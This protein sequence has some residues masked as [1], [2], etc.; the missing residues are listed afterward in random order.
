MVRWNPAIGDLQEWITWSG[1]NTFEVIEADDQYLLLPFS[2]GV[3][4]LYHA[5][6]VKDEFLTQVRK[7]RNG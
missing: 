2:S 7:V 5:Y 1:G 3:I 4:R 6:F